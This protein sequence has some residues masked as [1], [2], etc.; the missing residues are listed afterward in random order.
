MHTPAGNGQTRTEF[1]ATA[2]TLAGNL[3]TDRAQVGLWGF[4]R[5]LRGSKDIV[6]LEDV[7]VL[8]S[9]P[10]SHRDQLNASMAG[11]K[12]L[13]KGNG[14][15]LFQAAVAG[16]TEMKGQYDPRAGNAVVIFTDGGNFDKGGPTLN[17]TL[18][19]LAALY[20]PKK[21][22]RLICIGIGSGANMKQLRLMSSK[23][24]GQAFL[25]EKPEQLPQVL[26]DVMNRRG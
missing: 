3:L 21:P 9:G 2:A 11:A 25:A 1:A 18:A 15:A 7:A 19:D 13:L 12:N 17:Q 5:D 26:F 10:N 8:N 14:T 6:K 24:G 4:S 22:V 23:A 20:D 16:M